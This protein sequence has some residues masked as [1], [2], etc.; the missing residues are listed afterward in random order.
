MIKGK[1][2]LILFLLAATFAQAQ[3]GLWIR[4]DNRF[5]ENDVI[6]LSDKDSVVFTSTGI[7]VYANGRM[8]TSKA[9]SSSLDLTTADSSAAILFN[10]PGR[11][12]WKP[13]TSDKSYNNDYTK[14]TSRWT[15][16]RSQESE[17]FVVFW[18]K[19]FGANPNDKSVPSALRVD[20][21]DLLQKA[22]KFFDTNVNRLGMAVVG[23][24]QSQLDKYK[25]SIYLLYQTEW[26]ATGSGNDDIA[27]ALWVNP[28]T[29]KPVGHTIAHEI[30]HS[31]QFQVA[32]DKR[33]NGTSYYTDYGW[34]YGFGD[35]SSGG[36]CFWE[37]CAQWQGFQDYPQET[38]G[39][40]VSTWKKHY[41]RHFHH[42]WMRY[43]CYWLQ[44]VWTAKHGENAYGRIWRESKKPE[45]A[46]ET[47]TRLFCNNKLDQ[48]WEEYWKEYA[49][50]LPN[51]QFN[52]IHQY[53]TKDARSFPMTMYRT[54]D[55]YWQVAYASCPETSGVNI[56][57]LQVPKEGTEVKADFVG[58]NPGS[59][60]HPDDHGH[61]LSADDG[62]KY[63]VVTTYNN[64]G[65]A[66]YRGWRYGFVS[67]ANDQ[68]FT[69]EMF[70]DA[71]G[72]ANY[73]I[74]AGTEKLYFVVIGA[75]KKYNRH[76]WDDSDAN[77]VQWP[78]QV[79]F[80]GTERSGYFFFDDDAQP[81]DTTIA[82]TVTGD[83]SYETYQLGSIN[84]LDEGLMDAVMQAFKLPV[85]DFDSKMLPIAGGS[86][87]NP[88]E[89]KISF[90]MKSPTS[91]TYYYSYTANYGFWCNAS[92]IPQGYSTSIPVYVEYTTSSH[93]LDYGHQPKQGKGKSYKLYPAFVYKK[94]GKLYHAVLELTVKMQ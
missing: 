71:E 25:M 53:A 83:A 49:C 1:G 70:A 88:Q 32:A 89:G 12:L 86:S 67:I 37:Q 90:A 52:A 39:Y 78:Y 28:S 22:E 42:E 10:D 41:H 87:S 45:D 43:A 38:F 2:F 30:G 54:A 3:E 26:L 80:Q 31:F 36:N 84:L 17:H 4:H 20:I 57:Q 6:D 59:A 74:P 58:L 72:V 8:A 13:T 91:N 46:L 19:D 33:K 51:Y 69:S 77:D 47:Y 48:F 50:Q 81:C 94:N 16:E 56:I 65:K 5:T 23:E 85:A 9:Y 76:A 29:C 44:Y 73:T 75:P 11:I 79:R 60:L 64:I 15:F 93:T 24:N 82:Y 14:S 21:N 7:R 92:G 66:D 68:T 62:S 63:N 40:N 18:D 35:N 27:G 34:R 55:G 61:C